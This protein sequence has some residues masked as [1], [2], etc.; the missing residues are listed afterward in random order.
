M[1]EFFQPRS[2]LDI[3]MEV[4]IAIVPLLV[5]FMIYQIFFLKLP[6]IEV[7]KVLKG[8]GLTFVGLV[9][10]LYGVH[11][12][13]LPTGNTIG[14][15]LGALEYNWVLIPIGF[16]L[17]F[18]VTF[19][20]PAVRVLCKEVETASSGY[21]KEK[22]MLFTISA[23]VASSISLAMAR[24]LF[25]IHL[26]YFIL[27]GYI[28]ALSMAKII[29]P[30]FTAIAF[31]S[32]GVATGPMTVTFIMAIAVGAAD[33]IEG[34]DAIIDGFGLIALVALAPILSVVTLGL[35]YK[36]KERKNV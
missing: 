29:G 4:A 20:E 32:G 11:I 33:I 10:F 28:V 25:G 5:I 35:L 1:I 8:M 16:I 23:G 19:A 9:M 13:F 27:P 6:K 7:V 31:D 24:T 30:T 17:G 26:A 22:T 2:L 34:R 14:E 18:V 12:G 3:S 21:I 36:A 15:T